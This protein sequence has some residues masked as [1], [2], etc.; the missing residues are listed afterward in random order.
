M[1][2]TI[3]SI[4]L[5]TAG[6]LATSI[7]AQAFDL[8]TPIGVSAIA[9]TCPTGKS[10]VS[11]FYSQG[12]VP[13]PSTPY[14]GINSYQNFGHTVAIKSCVSNTT[15][16]YASTGVASS[17][18][19]TSW[20]KSVFAIA[21]MSNILPPPTSPANLFKSLRWSNIGSPPSGAINRFTIS[22]TALNP[23]VK[24]YFDDTNNLTGDRARTVNALG[25]AV[26]ANY[27]QNSINTVTI[28][29][30]FGVVIGTN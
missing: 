9:V 6:S 16:R 8:P 10:W 24:F 18:P 29:D 22:G 20:M 19:P 1:L 11:E 26:R 21:N 12:V 28:K 25:K 27:P 30:R 5:A 13:S 3:F 7:N 14:S 17:T 2:K 4:A 23:I 15:I